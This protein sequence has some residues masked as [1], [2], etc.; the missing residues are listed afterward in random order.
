MIAGLLVAPE[1]LAQSDALNALH[2]RQNK[3]FDQGKYREALP[4]GQQSLRMAEEEFGADDKRL[5]PYA[6]RL[7]RI[8]SVLGRRRA[9]EPLYRRALNITEA[10]TGPEDPAIGPYLNNLG[11]LYDELGQFGKAEPLFI[12]LLKILEAAHGKEHGLVALALNN[13][14]LLYDH[15][16]RYADAERLYKRSL[17]VRERLFGMDGP[18]LKTT[19]NNLAFLYDTLGRY[20]ESEATYTR[21][22]KIITKALGA[23]HPEA[24]IA[25]NNLGLLY[26]HQGRFAEA[27]VELK[28]ALAIRQKAFGADHPA[29]GASLNNIAEVYIAQGRLAEAE[30]LHRRALAIERKIS[31]GNSLRTANSLNNLGRLVSRLGNKEDAAQYYRQ[32]L[33]IKEKILSPDHDSIAL[34]LSNLALALRDLKNIDEAVAVQERALEI[35]TAKFGA[36]HLNV[37]GSLDNLGHLYRD[38]K[39]YDQAD[40]RYARSLA[41]KRAAL[42]PDH[43]S[44]ASTLNSLSVLRTRQ[45]RYQDSVRIRRQVTD[46]YRRR[47]SG[48]AFTG[49]AGGVSA[50]RDVRF[51]FVN[52]VIALVTAAKRIDLAEQDLVAES[53]EISQLAAASNTGEAVAGMSARFGAGS[54]EMAGLIRELQE[55]TESWRRA[56]QTLTRAAA[57][58]GPKRNPAAEDKLRR[59]MSERAARIKTL[60]SRLTAAFP[61]YAE[62][63]SPQPLS[64]GAVQSLLKTGEALMSYMTSRK[65]TYLWVIRRNASTLHSLKIGRDDLANSVR[66]LRRGLNPDEV[67]TLND[68]PKFDTAL[69]HSLYRQIFR[70]AEPSLEGIR[71]LFVVPDH[72]LQSL[73]LGVL[74]TDEPA[75]EIADFAGYRQVP[76]LARKYA[77]STLPS[78]SSLR[79]LRTFARRARAADP[80]IGIGDPVLDGHPGSSRGVR[81][82]TLFTSRGVAD[83]RAI[84]EL[85]SLP[86]TADE[87]AA[88][89]KSL[90]AGA[91]SLVLREAATERRVKEMDLSNA[92]VIA[93]A[94]HGLVAGDMAGLAEPAL[95]MTPPAT[96]SPTDDGL[97]TASEVARLNL[98]AGLVVL[99][100]CNTAAADGTPGAEAL[101]GL[102]K[103]FFFAGSRAL[104]VSHWPVASDAAVKL[105]TRMLALN[106]AQPGLGPAEALRRSMLELLQPHQPAHFA[107]PLFWAPFVVVG[108]GGA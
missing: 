16:S 71:H 83:V 38:L 104:L 5:A 108:E 62:L 95:V 41:I 58:S 81:L 46:I 56:D 96:A 60:D 42:G 107:H 37:A 36:D 52:H 105:T 65:R 97:L 33:A 8:Y 28:K 63:T 68:V 102:A 18:E 51:A 12:R 72:A 35:E 61:A 89:A 70:V 85:P 77:L 54:D 74:V 66:R 50:Q 47:T 29:V 10:A 19:L 21:A 14:A 32:S 80:F 90:G 3:L 76:W 13:L 6:N 82:S 24:A 31:G 73:P 53:F 100:A 103:A 7:G 106:T 101:T 44:L 67:E 34:T 84:K 25:I 1:A 15:M 86:E 17:R 27:E 79:A 2:Q 75:A 59:E 20:K 64:V 55:T 92:K 26:D 48:R 98:D 4:V 30:P 91:E 45:R 88:I 40:Q 22:L 23:E 57:L 11:R 39:E 78:V 99:S 94:T 93:F 87:L 43:P 49:S 9:A 69:A